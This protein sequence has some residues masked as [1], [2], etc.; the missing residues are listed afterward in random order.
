MAT[1]LQRSPRCM[2]KIHNSD[3]LGKNR[4]RTFHIKQG[5]WEWVR[6][7]ASKSVWKCECERETLKAENV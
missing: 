5:E 6:V 1:F 3:E 2:S 7:C 4:D